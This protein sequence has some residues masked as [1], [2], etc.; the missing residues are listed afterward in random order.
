LSKPVM[1]FF[2]VRS[3]RTGPPA[4][5]H[6]ARAWLALLLS[7]PSAPAGAATGA[8]GWRR[9]GGPGAF[10]ERAPP[11]RH[12]VYRHRAAGVKRAR[13]AGPRRRSARK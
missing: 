13:R 6:S 8:R 3:P 4:R 12:A 11:E 5:V 7:V 9:G 2:S 10:A 1:L